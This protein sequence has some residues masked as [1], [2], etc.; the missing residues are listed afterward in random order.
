MN[1]KFKLCLCHAHAVQSAACRNRTSM[2][3]R[4]LLKHAS[5]PDCMSPIQFCMAHGIAQH[6]GLCTYCCRSLSSISVSSDS[7]SMTS[8]DAALTKGPISSSSNTSSGCKDSFVSANSTPR[9][10]T[11]PVPSPP[12][13]QVKQHA[14]LA[15]C[16][17]T[18]RAD[19]HAVYNYLLSVHQGEA[20]AEAAP[21]ALCL[22]V[23][24]RWCRSGLAA[25]SLAGSWT[26]V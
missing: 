5:E 19:F 13:V 6:V 26:P 9:S 18:L 22:C 21:D 12:A 25:G 16:Q 4:L 11:A 8:R 17:A 7:S 24:Q 10:G 1:L 20:G 15:A 23:S 3:G 14:D 2:Q